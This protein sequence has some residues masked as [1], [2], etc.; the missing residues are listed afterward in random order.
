ME[1][2]MHVVSKMIEQQ[3]EW[4]KQLPREQQQQAREHSCQLHVQEWPG[5]SQNFGPCPDGVPVEAKY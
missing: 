2:L 3:H 4:T 5:Q 1:N